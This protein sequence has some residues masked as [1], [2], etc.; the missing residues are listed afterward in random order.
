MSE[1]ITIGLTS[2]LAVIT[3][4]LV[5]F[6][7]RKQ[8][9]LSH[10]LYRERDMLYREREYIEQ[11]RE[12]KRW[13]Q[14]RE[15]KEKLSEKSR[16]YIN[17]PSVSFHFADKDKIKSMYDEYF[18]EPTIT[19]V[20]SEK[21][22]SKDGKIKSA[23][24]H[25]LEAELGG[26]DIN[27]WI[28]NIKLPETSPSGMFKRYQRETIKNEQVDLSLEIIEAELFIV[29]EF[30]EKIK[31]FKEKY[32]F[33]IDDTAIK[34]QRNKLQE[35]ACKKTIEKLERAKDWVLIEGNF[36]IEKIGNEF[37]K[38]VLVH[39]VISYIDNNNKIIISCLIPIEKI[40]PSFS[41]NYASSIG[42][43]IP[44]RIYGQ[45]WKPIN[46]DKKEYELTITPLAVY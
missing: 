25:I 13:Q 34:T 22:N 24:P 5:Y 17:L 4:S 19:S 20:I 45:V 38:L 8:R 14:E 26:S 30:D 46:I 12:R 15:V 32:G 27:K 2:G 6:Y 33:E 37:Y 28:S 7:S 36:T 10:M 23:F 3:A 31:E 42:S 40:E 9:I 11:E 39:P 29:D 16:K 43:E 35:T 44:L 41:G 1:M 18:K 21:I